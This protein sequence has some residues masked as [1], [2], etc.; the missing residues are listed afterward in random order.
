MLIDG[1][2]GQKSI[3]A[4]MAII[5]IQG[6]SALFRRQSFLRQFASALYR[7]LRH[8][9]KSPSDH[10]L[11]AR[12]MMKPRIFGIYG[13]I[14]QSCDRQRIKSTPLPDASD[15][16]AA[17][18][19]IRHNVTQILNKFVTTSRRVEPIY[20]IA[21]TPWRD[22]K[23][24]KLLIIGCRNVL[25]LHQAKFAGFNWDNISGLDLFS[26][27]PKIMSMNMEDMN[28]INDASFDVV[29]MVNTLEYSLK[30]TQVFDEVNR[31]LRPGGRFVFTYGRHMEE[32]AVVSP[33]S[34][35]EFVDEPHYYP[36]AKHV[37]Y[38]H[39]IGMKLFWH[40]EISKENSVGLMQANHR[41]GFIKQAA[42]LDPPF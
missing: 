40:D 38:L 20:Q 8:P 39:D 14:V 28:G 29:T 24:E 6:R 22:L 33:A 18:R 26:I 5:L 30:P 25:E 32:K 35:E 31:I 3:H 41:L 17:A 12:L 11:F 10:R 21:T 34:G 13:L 42:L 15:Q 23:D 9:A 16:S 1:S 37:K 36:V 27:N 19:A 2:L 4:S 7:A